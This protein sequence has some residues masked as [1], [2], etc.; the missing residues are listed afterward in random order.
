MRRTANSNATRHEQ[1]LRGEA[2]RAI[3]GRGQRSSLHAAVSAASAGKK[4]TRKGEHGVTSGPARGKGA[5]RED[6]RA[7]G[8]VGQRSQ[9][10]HRYEPSPSPPVFD[11]LQ[12]FEDGSVE[13]QAGHQH[14]SPLAVLVVRHETLSSE[15]QSLFDSLVVASG[16]LSVHSGGSVSWAFGSSDQ[17]DF[18]LMEVVSGD[19]A[20]MRAYVRGLAIAD[21]TI[22]LLPVEHAL[23]EVVK[24]WLFEFALIARAL[25]VGRLIVALAMDWHEVARFEQSLPWVGTHQNSFDAVVGHLKPTLAEHGLAATQF[26][27]VSPDGERILR[28]P[29]S[30]GKPLL[31]LLEDQKVNRP[32]GGLAP[33]RM[34]MLDGRMDGGGRAVLIGRIMQGSLKPGS[35]V[36]LQPIKQRMRVVSVHDCTGT[37]QVVDFASAGECVQLHVVT[38]EDTPLDEV[39]N[40]QLLRIRSSSLWSL[41]AGEAATWL[42]EIRAVNGKPEGIQQNFSGM[43]HFG[44]EAVVANIMEFLEAF[45]LSTQLR[46]ISPAAALPG[47]LT[48]CILHLGQPMALDAYAGGQL[49]RF[50]LRCLGETVGVGK[51]LAPM[52]GL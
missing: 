47:H 16:G 51:I 42:I 31:N 18:T 17:R 50:I 3:P 49:G 24:K 13:E 37:R 2:T 30:P 14:S 5:L 41:H 23:D 22:L 9:V 39:L 46:S 1:R 40:P 10:K 26:L 20:N 38:E 32:I 11:Y 25:G 52:A 29:R 35:M 7:H 15:F 43:L 8:N 36:L 21:V 48:Q 12:D 28:P 27:P 44:A 34:L 33:L 6:T 45:D 4:G 19:K